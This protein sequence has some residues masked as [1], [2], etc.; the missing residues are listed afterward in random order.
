MKR[1]IVAGAGHGGLAAARRLAEAGCEVIVI[2]KESREELGYDWRDCISRRS[3]KRAGFA[4]LRDE[5]MFSFGDMSYTNHAKTV[6]FSTHSGISKTLCMVERKTLINHLIDGAE[7]AGVRF[8]FEKEIDGPIFENGRVLGVTV[9]DFKYKGDLIIDAAGIDSPVRCNLP[10]CSGIIREITGKDVFTVYRAC[11]EKAEDKYADPPYAICFNHCG[12]RGMDWVITEEEWVD[13]LVGAFGELTEDDIRKAVNDYRKEYPYIG[14]KILRGGQVTKIPLRRTLP[15]IVCSGYAAVG[16]SASMTYPLSGSGIDNSLMAG[17]MLAE[18][19]IKSGF[20][21]SLGSLW[22]Y[23]YDYFKK[24]QEHLLGEDLI[25]NALRE[26]S[27]EELDYLFEN[28]IIGE[29]DVI[30]G[31]PDFSDNIK[32][33][34]LIKRPSAMKK[35]L[36]AASGMAKKKK[37]CAMMPAEYDGEE[38]TAWKKE[39]EGL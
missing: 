11:Y 1:V 21:S 3:I 18:T 7:A 8:E 27:A 23:Q 36:R 39:Y 26:M 31:K 35:L 33:A 10:A 32:K 9:R 13:I 17:V 12:K 15:A 22:H 5:D 25:K 29:K 24:K 30:G 38:F 4:P 34:K 37:V 2:E 20:D 6:K 14:T 19:Y 16:D 28:G